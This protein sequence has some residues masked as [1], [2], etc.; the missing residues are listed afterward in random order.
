MSDHHVT[1]V[2]DVGARACACGCGRPRPAPP[3]GGGRTPLYASHA[4]QQR[5]YRQRQTAARATP[6]PVA[7]PPS[8]AALLRDIRE[9][10][11]VLDTGGVA[12]DGLTAAVRAGTRD[13]LART[14]SAAAPA[15]PGLRLVTE[16]VTPPAQ[17]RPVAEAAV[18]PAPTTP[19]PARDDRPRRRRASTA[20]PVIMR[21]SGRPL[22]AEI[23]AA[24]RAVHAAVQ[25]DAD[26]A[27]R[28]APAGASA[29]W[30]VVLGD[31]R[32]GW[33]TRDHHRSRGWYAVSLTLTPGRTARRTR[34]DAAIDVLDDLVDLAG[35]ARPASLRP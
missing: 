20:Q 30:Q 17:E 2:L 22:G 32:L 1:T 4:C 7:D 24:V 16:D 10:A 6:A 15:G 23:S 28:R 25:A 13:L 35:R 11:A 8:V 3:A 34:H 14:S 18:D 31:V 26:L 5:A 21:D 29:D 9:L 12:P 27:V 19:P 33:I